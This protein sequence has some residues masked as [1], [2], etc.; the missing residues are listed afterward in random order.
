MT[1]LAP[2]TERPN[3]ARLA[4]IANQL[5]RMA[6]QEERYA[7]APKDAAAQLRRDAD[8]LDSLSSYQ[9]ERERQLEAAVRVL[10]RFGYG[11]WPTCPAPE[12]GDCNCGYDAAWGG[13]RALLSPPEGQQRVVGVE[14][15]DEGWAYAEIQRLS[16][17]LTDHFGGA[18]HSDESAVDDAIGHIRQLGAALDAILDGYRPQPNDALALA[19]IAAARIR[20]PEAPPPTPPTTSVAVQSYTAAAPDPFD[21]I[22]DGLGEPAAVQSYRLA[23][24]EGCDET[25]S[26]CQCPECYSSAIDKGAAFC[27]RVGCVKRHPII[28]SEEQREDG[29]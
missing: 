22:Y 10:L 25:R 20:R 18:V 3:A 2:R 7:Y 27:N 12:M 26:D 6:D 1:L 23:P 9:G 21:A 5:R 8:Y 13:A 4:N 17:F 19:V 16:E 14:N 24:I 29:E 28:R 15:E 11:H